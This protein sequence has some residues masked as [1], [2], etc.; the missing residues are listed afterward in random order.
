MKLLE[1]CKEILLKFDLPLIPEKTEFK[2]E[3]ETIEKCI[4][5][6]F[7]YKE[8]IKEL[9]KTKF[10]LKHLKRFL[11]FFLEMITKSKKKSIEY[12]KPP[13]FTLFK[14]PY[15]S[16]EDIVNF[17][18]KLYHLWFRSLYEYLLYL[19]RFIKDPKD[20]AAAIRAIVNEYGEFERGDFLAIEVKELMDLV[21]RTWSDIALETYQKKAAL[22]KQYSTLV[23]WLL[24][25]GKYPEHNLELILEVAVEWLLIFGT[26]VLI[27]FLISY[28]VKYVT[29]Q[30]K[31]EKE[32]KGARYTLDDE[33]LI[34]AFYVTILGILL[35]HAS[36][37]IYSNNYFS[38]IENSINKNLINLIKFLGKR[39]QIEAILNYKFLD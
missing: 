17:Y 27:Y 5:F 14:T 36:W 26:G 10:N 18:A 1:N 33:V 31:K 13:A 30:L 11:K 6:D 25:I 38:K 24:G 39:F 4:K 9:I 12:I 29:N 16:I 28:L 21:Q 37:F 23:K 35:G 22:D 32:K 20:I 15:M 19:L 34:T 3:I 8:F 7:D 2:L